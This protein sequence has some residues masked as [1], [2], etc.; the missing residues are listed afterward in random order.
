MKLN[1]MQTLSPSWLPPV[2]RPEEAASTALF[3]QC[4]LARNLPGFPFPARCNDAELG[5]IE[6]RVLDALSGAGMMSG[7]AYYRAENL[8][9]S[10]LRFLSER[11]LFNPNMF[12]ATGARGV[13]VSEN[14][15]LAV[16]INGEDHVWVRAIRPGLALHDTWADVNRLDDL[17]LARLDF[18]FHEQLG[19]L[20]SDL[21]L[22][23]CGLRASVLLHVPGL[24]WTGR[25]AECEADTAET[26]WTALRGVCL[27][28]NASDV[29][30]AFHLE[31]DM[32][33]SASEDSLGALYQ[34]FNGC[35]LG[36]GEEEL[37]F[38]VTHAA[39]VF[40]ECERDAR[41]GLMRDMPFLLEDRVCRARGV[42]REAR[43]LE[44]DEAASV[45]SL[46][47]L[48]SE[49]GLIDDVAPAQLSALLLSAQ[50]GHIEVSGQPSADTETLN[51]SRAA[52]FRRALCQH[53]N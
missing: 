26:S 14:Q 4:T 28:G 10:E 41:A 38:H 13:F 53:E 22:T 50:R 32:S 40:Q 33:S 34:L 12:A 47:R 52:L 7:G 25:L 44:F 36:L 6:Q 9:I 37:L 11:R 5:E 27:A 8:S 48:G 23:G 15:S 1:A 35:T 29:M 3:S 42:A 49:S 20:T 16:M 30:Q 39:G 51:K 31:Y 19:F 24:E 2:A 45:L 43:L 21:G 18:V 46:L 17:L